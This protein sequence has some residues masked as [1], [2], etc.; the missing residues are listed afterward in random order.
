[1]IVSPAMVRWPSSTWRRRAG[2]QIDV[3]PAAEADQADAL[4]GDDAVADLDPGHDP[5]RDQPGDLGEGDLGAVL[6]LDQDVLA[7]IVLARLVEI[8]VEELAGD[9]DDAA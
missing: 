6:A 1:M 5:A 2:G 9:I 7:L 3:D 4:A 8:G